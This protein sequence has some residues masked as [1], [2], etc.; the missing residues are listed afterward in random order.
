M[1]YFLKELFHFHISKLVLL[2]SMYYCVGMFQLRYF[3]AGIGKVCLNK[4]GANGYKNAS[5]MELT[6]MYI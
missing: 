1:V 6:F 4:C 3:N 2:K 5:N